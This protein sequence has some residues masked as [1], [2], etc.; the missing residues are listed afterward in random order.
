MKRK[1]KMQLSFSWTYWTR[2]CVG[3]H[4]TRP[5]FC[6]SNILKVEFRNQHGSTASLRSW[7][8]MQNLKPPS[9]NYWNRIWSLIKY[10]GDLYVHQ[11][12][13]S[14]AREHILRTR[15]KDNDRNGF[16]LENFKN[17]FYSSFTLASEK[18]WYYFQRTS[19]L[20]QGVFT[21]KTTSEGYG[22]QILI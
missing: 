4:L 17:R 6:I 21:M 2:D 7:S 3:Q 22:K 18:L 11:S 20:V 15:A 10:S 12:L 9:Q 8:E 19:V 16:N 1:L 5:T 14:K 13:R